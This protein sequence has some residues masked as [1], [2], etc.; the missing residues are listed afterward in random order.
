MAAKRKYKWREWFDQREFILTQGE[1]YH[2]SQSTMAQVVR[3]NASKRGLRVRVM[4]TGQ[5]IEVKV[6]GLRKA[7]E[8]VS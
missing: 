6:T 8:E 7:Y 3:N 2:C 5:Q 4:D 1:H